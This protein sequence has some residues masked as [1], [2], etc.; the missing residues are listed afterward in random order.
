M[1]EEDGIWRRNTTQSPGAGHVLWGAVLWE[2]PLHPWNMSVLL[3]SV[4]LYVL[5]PVNLKPPFE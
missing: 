4:Q 5:H 3:Y 2:P 1:R